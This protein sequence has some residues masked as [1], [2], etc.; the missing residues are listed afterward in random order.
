MAAMTSRSAKLLAV[1]ALLVLSWGKASAQM[2]CIITVAPLTFGVYTP[3]DLVPLDSTGQLDISCRGQNGLLSVAMS[4]GTS[5]SFVSREMQSG[6]FAMM[7]N[8]FVDAA[9]SIIWG[10]GTGGTTLISLVK[11]TSGRQDYTLP[12]HGRIPAQQSVAAGTYADDI[13]ITVSF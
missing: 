9:R 8:I 1:A 3:G 4:T 13:L 10:D 7:Y 11:Q 2:N 12:V 5:G 6:V